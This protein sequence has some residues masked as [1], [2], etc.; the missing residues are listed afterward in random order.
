MANCKKC[1]GNVTWK[2][3]GNR[4]VCHNAGTKTDHWDSC[5][6]RR[7]ERIMATGL[8][9]TK[10]TGREYI[11]GFKTDLKPSGEMLMLCAH[12]AI[13]GK[14]YRPSGDCAQCVPPWEICGWPCPDAIK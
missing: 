11:E 10:E 2:K 4:W 5:S 12:V 3:I 1:G 7:T 6:K 14:H 13:R 8:P 9:F